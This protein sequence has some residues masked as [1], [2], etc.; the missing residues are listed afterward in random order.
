V[1]EDELQLCQYVLELFTKRGG[2][3]QVQRQHN[4]AVH[5]IHSPFGHICQENIFYTSNFV[6]L[7]RLWKD[8]KMILNMCLSLCGKL[9]LGLIHKGNTPDLIGIGSIAVP[10]LE[11]PS[12]HL[13]F[14]WN[15]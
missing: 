9:Q 5:I 12:R 1:K 6:V 15:G 11:L 8:K 3:R 13:V 14:K 7:V 4:S 2:H 10:D